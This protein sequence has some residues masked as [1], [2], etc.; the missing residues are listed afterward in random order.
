LKTTDDFCALIPARSG[1]KGVHKK[2]IKLLGNHPLLAYSIA[3]CLKSNKI[4]KIVVSTDCE[5]IA[6]IAKKY[7]AEVPFLRPKELSEDNSTDY[8]VLCHF[9]DNINVDNAVY[10]RPTSPLRLSKIIDK[11]IEFFEKNKDFCSGVRSMKECS[12]PPYKL[13]KIND[14]GICEGFFEDFKGIKDYTNLPRQIFPKAYLP[15]GYVDVCKR[16]T[17]EKYKTAF[18]TN[19]MPFITANIT[20]VDT[21][22]DF[23]L[24]E[25]DLNF[26]GH[27]LKTF[28]DDLF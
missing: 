8:D 28:L 9:Y 24:L 23:T 10:I 26:T 16:S 11:G 27:E 18:G 14:N 1:S 17:L 13:F 4:N 22:G 7:G 3:A 25:A 5:E 19:I 21:E 12:H 15:N 6:S 2:N 20:D